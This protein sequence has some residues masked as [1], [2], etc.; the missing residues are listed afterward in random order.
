MRNF[1]I[2]NH[3]FMVDRI[4][5]TSRLTE[6]TGHRLRL[7]LYICR[8]VSVDP[9]NRYFYS[10]DRA[11]KELKMTQSS[12]RGALKWLE[13]HYFIK[14]TGKVSRAN[15]Y[16]V[17]FL[18]LFDGTNYYSRE[19]LKRDRATFK[20]EGQGYVEFPVELFQGSILANK[21][22]WS[23]LRL[24]TIGLLY[25]YFW[26]D[27]YGGIDSN[28]LYVDSNDQYIIDDT[29]YTDLNCSHNRLINNID[30]L[31][32]QGLL[33][34]VECIYRENKNSVGKEYQY[35]GDASVTASLP[36]DKK[37]KLLRFNIIPSHK[38]TNAQQRTNQGVLV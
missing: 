23:D 28:V 19:N 25:L 18:P 13:D 4:L 14:K 21:T 20:H 15:A 26:I 22:L 17:L 1:I 24:R 33:T 32:K 2:S 6:L 29:L 12:Y 30:F 36:N 34:K 31:I 10:Y 5:F 11:N 7:Y 16:Q 37:I 8:A 3:T 38:L 9:N 27:V 35:I